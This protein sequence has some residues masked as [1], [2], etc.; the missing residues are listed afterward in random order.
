MRAEFAAFKARLEAHP[1]LVGKV[2][3]IVRKNGDEP[4]RSNYLVARSSKPDRLSDDRFTGVDS[5]ESDRR[6]T[7]DVR[8]VGTSADALDVLGEPVLIQ[9][10]GHSLTVSGRRC[11]PI[12]LV[13]DVEEGDGYDRT[14]DLYYRDMSFRFWSRRP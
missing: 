7:Y 5:F 10:V 8:V 14:A 1:V 11:S 2:F 3:P 9:L 12:Q 4:V 13:P 6:F